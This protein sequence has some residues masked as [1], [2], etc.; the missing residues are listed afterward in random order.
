MA[1]RRHYHF[2]IVSDAGIKVVASGS[3]EIWQGNAGDNPYTA[4]QATQ[5][6]AALDLVCVEDG[7]WMENKPD[8]NW[9]R[10]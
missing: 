5:T 9:G 1:D 6:G 4:L 3:D 2:M 10:P 8:M 7:V